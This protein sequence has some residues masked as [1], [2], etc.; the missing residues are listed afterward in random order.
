M[1]LQDEFKKLA[2][3]G[4]KDGESGADTGADVV[5]DR[6]DAFEPTAS[7]AAADKLAL[8]AAEALAVA[9]KVKE[10]AAAVAAELDDPEAAAAAKVAA[11]KDTRIPAARHKEILERERA[12]RTDLETKLAQYE[13]G[14]RLADTNEQITAAETGLLKLEA[15]YSKLLVD[16]DHVKATTVM[17]EIR[18]TER[19]II[20]SKAAMATQAAESRAYERVRYDTTV[21]RL[22]LAFPVLNPDDKDNYDAD[23]VKDVTELMQ[24]YQMKGYTPSDAIQKAAKVLLRPATPKQ[25]AAVEVSPRVSAEDAAKKVVE[26]RKKAQLAINLAAAGKQPPTSKNVGADSD[27]A[28]GTLRGSDAIRLPYQDFIKLDEATLSRMRGDVIA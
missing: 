9:T 6:G 18:T 11:A 1:I 24:A 25:D 26:E 7:D 23:A 5:V 16:G 19:A 4:E 27:K 28:G 12:L 20:E 8:E 17:R 3:A 15:E 13:K 21:E 22:E 14:G 10:D 2:T